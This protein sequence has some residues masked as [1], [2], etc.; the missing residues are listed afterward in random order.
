MEQELPIYKIVVNDDEISGVEFISLVTDP[1]IESNFIMLNKQYQFKFDSDKKILMGPLLIPDKKIYRFSPE[2]GEYYLVF[3][4]DTIKKIVM[5]YNKNN[6]N[7]KINVQHNSDYLVDAFLT[8][9]WIIEDENFDKSKKYKFENLP[10]GTWMGSVYIESDEFWNNVVKTGEVKGFS[11]E[12][13]AEI[14]QM[15]SKIHDTCEGLCGCGVGHTHDEG[16]WEFVEEVMIRAELLRHQ[17]EQDLKDGKLEFRRVKFERWIAND[18][19]RTCPICVTLHNLGWQL[20]GTFFEYSWG[21]NS[22]LIEM[23]R[24]RQAHSYVGEGRWKT[25]NN[26]CRCRKDSFTTDSNNPRLPRI[27]II[28]L[29]SE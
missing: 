24:F 12:L 1:A 28:E 20:Q 23:P 8:E 22:K 13:V 21:S 26:V 7:N 11:V 18:D 29:E 27:E 4:E 14:E 2:M 3:D 15:L 16:D 17:Y 6:N 19:E 10:V 9:N 5:K 25:G